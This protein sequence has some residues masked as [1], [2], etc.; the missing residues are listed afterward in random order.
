M[1]VFGVDTSVITTR[2]ER[3]D[4]NFGRH[5]LIV[6]DDVPVDLP[7]ISLNCW[8]GAAAEGDFGKCW[9]IYP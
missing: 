7:H 3:A 6:D 4:N 8:V 9:P 1:V 2:M 5:D